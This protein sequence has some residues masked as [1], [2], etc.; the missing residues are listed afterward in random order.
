[1]A[2]KKEIHPIVLVLIFLGALLIFSGLSWFYL[3]SPVDRGKRNKD[4]Y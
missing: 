2:V 1:M 3:V 4:S